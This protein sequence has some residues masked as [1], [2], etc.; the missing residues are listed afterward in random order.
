MRRCLIFCCLIWIFS[1]CVNNIDVSL[2]FK[3][4]TVVYSMLVAGGEPVV[5]LYKSEPFNIAISQQ[6]LQYINDAEVY[7]LTETDKIKLQ[8]Q[9]RY[10]KNV[11]FGFF[12]PGIDKLD[13]TLVTFYTASV[14]IEAGKKYR[15]EVKS[16]DEFL[17][18][19]T[20]VP[21]LVEPL[22]TNII[23]EKDKDDEGNEYLADIL[24]IKFQDRPGEENYYKYRVFYQQQAFSDLL[25][26]NG[27]LI[28]TDTINVAYNFL[29]S[30]FLSDEGNDGEVFTIRFLMNNRVNT[31]GDTSYVFRLNS[32]IISYSPDLI[33][34]NR[35]LSNQ[36]DDGSA[37][38][39]FREPVI[40]KSNVKGGLGIFTARTESTIITL[41]YQPSFD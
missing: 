7:L 31:Y 5:Y 17:E 8:V 39:P 26:S 40:V 23:T 35:S 15:L 29:R 37:L 9:S 10:E 12:E 4:K 34:F 25:D 28:R 16:G 3:E 2:N 24:E 13:S 27:V 14:K 18:A 6:P 21:F 30:R 22:S 33:T 36:N 32:N 1:S 19:E 11:F 41:P 20:T 38:D